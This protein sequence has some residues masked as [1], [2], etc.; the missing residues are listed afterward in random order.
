MAEVGKFIERTKVG[1]TPSDSS[2]IKSE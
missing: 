1:D 2:D